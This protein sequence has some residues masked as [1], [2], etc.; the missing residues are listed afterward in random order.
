MNERTRALE[1]ALNIKWFR[2]AYIFGLFKRII[3]L[4]SLRLFD[5]TIPIG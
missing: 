5:L 1:N 4:L 3:T 2:K